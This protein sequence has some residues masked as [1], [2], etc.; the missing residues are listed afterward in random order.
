MPRA[1]LL[2]CNTLLTRSAME[3]GPHHEKQGEISITVQEQDLCPVEHIVVERVKYWN[4]CC[5][6]ENIRNRGCPSQSC[7]CHHNG[8]EELPEE[9]QLWLQPQYF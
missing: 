6:I 3:L 8:I 2:L 7:Q 9:V 1:L 5:R 4:K